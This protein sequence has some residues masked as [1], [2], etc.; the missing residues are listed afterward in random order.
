VGCTRR[1]FSDPLSNDLVDCHFRPD[2]PDRLWVQNLTQ[3]ERWV[4]L[5]GH[6]C[7]VTP[8]R[9]LVDR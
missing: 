8:R 1:R 4:Y 9:G 6:R 5:R 7:L 2:A 3:A